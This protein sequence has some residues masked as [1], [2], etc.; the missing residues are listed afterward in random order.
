MVLG[1]ELDCDI[2]SE[3]ILHSTVLQLNF[4]V[5]LMSFCYQPWLVFLLAMIFFR[6]ISVHGT[7]KKSVNI[8]ETIEFSFSF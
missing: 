7:E 1:F 8:Q 4:G 2:S 5:F 3:F 6:K